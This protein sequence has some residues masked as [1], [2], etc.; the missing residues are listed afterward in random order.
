MLIIIECFQTL[1]KF[2]KI[3]QEKFNEVWDFLK[4]IRVNSQLG[5]GDD[6][7]IWNFVEPK[8]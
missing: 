2:F 7:K 8:S 1:G 6:N 5:N 4:R 3:G